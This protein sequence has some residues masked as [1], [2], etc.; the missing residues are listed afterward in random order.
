MSNWQEMFDKQRPAATL[1]KPEPASDVASEPEFAPP[2]DPR[3]YKPWIL[4]RGGRPALFIDLRRFDPK[5]GFL[6]GCQMSY[7]HLV[8]VDYIGDHMVALDFGSR[9]FVI[10]GESLSELPPR[11][12]QGSVLAIQQYSTQ[13]WRQ[14]ARGPVINALIVLGR[15]LPGAERP[16]SGMKHHTTDR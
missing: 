6:I 5:A 2:P 4:Q 1:V 8:A 14:H 9:Q 3:E 11:I 15:Q 13:I 12:Q 7:P 16:A 10:E